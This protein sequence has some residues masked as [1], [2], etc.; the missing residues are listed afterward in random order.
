MMLGDGGGDGGL[1]VGGGGVRRVSLLV[2]PAPDGSLPAA[3][4][5]ITLEE[6]GTLVLN[7]L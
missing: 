1:G 4:A 3:T 5:I 6:C 2:Y 7:S